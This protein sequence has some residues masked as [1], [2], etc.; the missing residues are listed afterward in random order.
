MDLKKGY[1][2][3]QDR[4]VKRFCQYMKLNPNTI[5]TYKYWHK[6]ENIW[7]EIPIGIRQAGILDMEIY[8]MEEYACMIIETS[9]DFDFDTAFG[10]LAS[11][12]RQAEW[13]EFVSTFQITEKGKRSDEKWQLIP[14]IFS[15]KDALDL[16]TNN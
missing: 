7:K 13:E 6:S 16:N 9:I 2:R 8:L 5:E 10:N 3:N 15:L 4:T 1:L 11:Y 12:D 14:R